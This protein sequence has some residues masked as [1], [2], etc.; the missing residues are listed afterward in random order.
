MR[1]A[2]YYDNEFNP[3]STDIELIVGIKEKDKADRI[4]NGQLCART[5]HKGPYS[6]LSDAYGALVAWIEK[7]HYAWDGAPYEI[8]T[9]TQ[10]DHLSPED[11][12]TEIYFPISRPGDDQK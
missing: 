5:V 6:S 10:F 11:W 12:E 7:N 9:K 2:I 3:E 8:Y 1:G 4:M